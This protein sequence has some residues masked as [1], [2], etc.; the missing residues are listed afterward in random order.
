ML[1]LPSVP[2]YPPSLYGQEAQMQ[3]ADD[4]LETIPPVTYGKAPLSVSGP[5]SVGHSTSA[6]RKAS[7]SVYVSTTSGSNNHKIDARYQVRLAVRVPTREV[8]ENPYGQGSCLI[9]QMWEMP[10]TMGA[11]NWTARFTSRLPQN[12]RPML[13]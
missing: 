8:S 9:R 6:A 3:C 2:A 4:N 5:S 13:N 11:R 1:A 12:Y 10:I 7:A